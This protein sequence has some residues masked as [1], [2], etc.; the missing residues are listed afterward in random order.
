MK[1]HT[2]PN[3]SIRFDEVD[4]KIANRLNID[5]PEVCRQALK[6]VI[7]RMTKKCPNCGASNE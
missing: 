3:R 2:K 6:K 1:T 5:I 7:L 4:L